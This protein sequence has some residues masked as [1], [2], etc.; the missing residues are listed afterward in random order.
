MRTA[1]ERDVAHA[2]DDFVVDHESLRRLHDFEIGIVGRA[3]HRRPFI[4]P[5]NTALRQGAI[6][7]AFGARA[8]AATST[9]CLLPSSDSGGILPSGG[10]KIS[11]VRR[12]DMIF[13]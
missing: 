11:D 1:V 2:V 8:A 5:R 9:A 10:S 13:W 4:T 6:L 7:S 3:H 12:F